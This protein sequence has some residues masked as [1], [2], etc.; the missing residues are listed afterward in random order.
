MPFDKTFDH[1]PKI[2][3]GRGASRG[4]RGLLFGRRVEALRD[5]A[6][7]DARALA[8][9]AESDRGVGAD[10]QLAGLAAML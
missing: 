3:I 5:L 4:L 9:D 10:R 1:D 7:G 2:M 8:G 6:Q